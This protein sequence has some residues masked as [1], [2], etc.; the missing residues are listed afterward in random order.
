[1]RV[2]R[3]EGVFRDVFL[4][5]LLGA[6]VLA[7]WFGQRP[8]VTNA[9]WVF[10]L[11]TGLG[12]RRSPIILCTLAG[13]WFG[14]AFGSSVSSSI[15]EMPERMIACVVAGLGLGFALDQLRAATRKGRT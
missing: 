15:E 9:I 13:A 5:A 4:L 1:M 11:A 14:F 12:L 8:L 2:L 6:P 10:Y 3:L 7:L